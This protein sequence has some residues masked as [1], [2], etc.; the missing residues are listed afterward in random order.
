MKK[1]L[2]KLAKKDHK[3][4]LDDNKTFYEKITTENY[5][6]TKISESKNKF[7]WKKFS[8]AMAAVL[9][10]IVISATML[11]IFLP[12]NNSE[13]ETHYAEDNFI[14]E[15]KTESELKNNIKSVSFNFDDTILSLIL[16]TSDSESGDE[17]FYE[18][19]GTSQDYMQD[20]NIKIEINPYFHLPCNRDLYTNSYTINDYEIKYY[21]KSSEKQGIYTLSSFA[22]IDF[23]TEFFII[24]YN[25]YSL[26]PEENNFF[27]W[28]GNTI[29]KK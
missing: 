5:S 15:A 11:V 27:N 22:I 3:K 6:L 26:E 17:L 8:F 9:L 1:D 24:E 29:T 21:I 18:L 16:L 2:R 25:Q 14:N 28:L 4:I 23:K 19:N 13:E 20:W 12:D 7:S 10:V